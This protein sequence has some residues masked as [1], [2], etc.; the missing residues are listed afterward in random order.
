MLIFKLYVFPFLYTITTAPAC[1]KMRDECPC[2]VSTKSCI[3]RA[4][5]AMHWSTVTC[6][7]LGKWLLGDMTAG[8]DTFYYSSKHN[9]LYTSGM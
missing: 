4:C 8:Y 7:S 9:S 2:Q 3:L 5:K 6:V 1:S